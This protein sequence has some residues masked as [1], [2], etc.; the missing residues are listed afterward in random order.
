VTFPLCRTFR[1]VSAMAVGMALFVLACQP[2]AVLEKPP[3]LTPDQALFA[4]AESDFEAGKYARAM[5]AYEAYR[6]QFPKGLNART[7]LYRISQIFTLQYRY[8]KALAALET[9]V[10]EY[11]GDPQLAV[12]EYD[13]AYLHYRLGNYEQSRLNA[14]EWISKYPDHPRR[15]DIF[16]LLGQNLLALQDRPKAFYWWRMAFDALQE[17][18]EEQQGVEDRMIGLIESAE[19][20]ELLE[21]AGY[22][23][24]SV[25]APPIYYNIAS[26]YLARHKYEEARGAAMALVRAT[27]EQFWVD[28]GRRILD[29]VAWELS[30]KTNAIGCLL[31]LSGPFAIYG[32]EVLNGIQLGMGLFSEFEEN[33]ALELIIKDTAGDARQTVSQLEKLA[34]E[35][36]VVAVVGPLAS[37]PAAA[38]SQKAEELNVPIITLTQREGITAEGDMVFRNFLTPSKQM[39]TLLQR[40][41]AE[42]GLSRFGILYPDN[43]YGH[44]FMNLF[45][46]ELESHGGYVT[47][48]ES[49]NPEETDF[50]A[51]I[52]KMVGLYYPRPEPLAQILEVLNYPP[53]E[54]EGGEIEPDPDEEPEPIADFDAVFIPDNHQR[55]ALIAPQ[56]PFYSV[57]NMTFLGTS[58]WQSPELIDLA[59]DY[60]QGA[61][62]PSGFFDGVDGEAVETFVHRYRENFESE[63]GI[64]AATGYDTITLLKHILSQNAIASRQDLHKALMTDNGFYGVTGKLSFDQEREVEKEPLLLTVRGSRLVP[65]D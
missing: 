60:L 10:R 31:P 52:K 22:A 56:F 62:F 16:V 33:P 19:L 48:V 14:I 46:D 8:E 4:A 37:K 58:L 7:A 12:V 17:S 47:A 24:G 35:S 3:E 26:F 45:W 43:R 2:K 42:M 9:L 20:E 40:G 23:E 29:K 55:V 13:M 41:M 28:I 57:F 34:T 54:L 50:A 27:P 61:V 5:D 44:Y 38:A 65:L 53:D 36:R 39:K 63:P 51:Q 49:Y 30:V 25:F 64:L 1:A 59:G 6:E 11:P 15:G 21:M 32:Q 18:R